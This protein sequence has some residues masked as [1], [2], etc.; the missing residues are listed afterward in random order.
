MPL[1]EKEVYV[2][3]AKYQGLSNDD[4]LVYLKDH[5]HKM[6]LA[7]YYR[8]L[9]KIDNDTL[10]RLFEIAR[11]Q[12]ER[13]RSRIDTL[14]TVEKLQWECYR[15]EGDPLKKSKILK[16]IRET[17]V[18]LSAFDQG[19]AGVIEEVT[20]DFGKGSIR[21]ENLREGMSRLFPEPKNRRSRKKAS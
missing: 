12:K 15:K 10:Q 2:I 7:T 14:E 6:S 4:V 21:E 11:T 5:D 19:A 3:S 8:T 1:N 17:Q 20:K 16:D 13:Y 18:Y 9:G